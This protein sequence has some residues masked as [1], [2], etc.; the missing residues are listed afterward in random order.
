VNSYTEIA[1]FFMRGGRLQ[2]LPDYAPL[3]DASYLEAV[4]A[5]N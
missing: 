5:G 1:K 2:E 3:V 4:I